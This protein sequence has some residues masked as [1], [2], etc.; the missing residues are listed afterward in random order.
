MLERD[1]KK[2][3]KDDGVHS[4]RNLPTWKIGLQKDRY[5]A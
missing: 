5:S 2:G 1:K 3:P 4:P